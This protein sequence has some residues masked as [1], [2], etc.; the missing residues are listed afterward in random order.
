MLLAGSTRSP[1]I[2]N[3]VL[4]WFEGDIFKLNLKGKLFDQDKTPV[5]FPE[6]ATL[7]LCVLNERREIVKEFECS[8]D[9][10]G[11]IEI[12]IDEET[13]ALFPWG[14][15]KGQMLFDDGEKHVTIGVY[16][17]IVGDIDHHKHNKY[18]VDAEF[19]GWISRGIEH[20]EVV[21][22]HLILTLTD[23][24]IIDLGN[25]RGDQ[26]VSVNGI[27][28][29]EKGIFTIV[30]SDGRTEAI[31]NDLYTAL[32]NLKDLASTYANDA[33]V[34]AQESKDEAYNAWKSA[35]AATKAET[36][37]KASKESAEASANTATAEAG[38]AAESRRQ[39]GIS[40]DVAA[41]FANSASAQAT[42]SRQSA[43]EAANAASDALENKQRTEEIYESIIDTGYAERLAAVEAVNTAQGTALQ[44][45][46]A[47]KADKT[48][49]AALAAEVDTK[50]DKTALDETNRSL[51]FL[52]KLN[53][54]VTWDI[55]Q[56][57]E[58]GHAQL[59]KGGVYG[60]V[61][62]VRGLT[63]QDGEPTPDNPVEI[64]SVD[65]IR[66]EKTGANLWDEEWEVGGI[67]ATTG[68]NIYSVGIRTKNYIPVITGKKYFIG[69][70]GDAGLNIKG[71][72]Y[73][74]NKNFVS[75]IA[76]K[77]R[78]VF[79]IPNGVAYLRFSPQ[80]NYGA[81]YHNDIILA[82]SDVAVP[83]EPYRSETRTIIPPR[84]LNAIGEYKDKCNVVS[85]EWEWHSKQITE[86][87]YT[88]SVVRE[89]DYF[90]IPT[91]TEP[92]SPTD[93]DYLRNLTLNAG[94]NLFITDNHG[95]DVSYLM[96]DFINLK[97]ALT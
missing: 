94:E 50:A 68:E 2:P 60:N 48:E 43:T 11:N 7:T 16:E 47:N 73:D 5:E 95:R 34:R 70:S 53:E 14:K 28:I 31:G 75:A 63:T 21:E 44:R 37:A 91:Q 74:K 49:V 65:E 55:E 13:T 15:Y 3:G 57:E 90:L 62:E 51:D 42:A 52:W 71:R 27:T 36:D 54:G 17:I 12:N 38:A 35:N 45:L 77:Y 40:S 26:G 89:A 39:A 9:E 22:G 18:A 30:Y 80:D 79:T 46:E 78:T 10:N 88:H 85:G 76:P 58:S 97:E 23:G 6:G 61:D 25:V 41:A 69:L 86:A 20:A 56:R 84:P 72:C 96:S 87:D 93:L 29:D 59:P 24:C 67:S 66:I 64:V 32:L 19:M 82:Q 81:V 8:P 83:Y 92:I 33:A 4:A 1:S